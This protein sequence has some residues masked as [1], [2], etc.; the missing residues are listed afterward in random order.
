ME[1]RVGF[2]PTMP[3]DITVF[4]T[5]AFGHSAIS[6]QRVIKLNKC[7]TF[8]EKINKKTAELS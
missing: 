2:E 1:E 6:P 3:F 8:K 7:K 5:A 4:K